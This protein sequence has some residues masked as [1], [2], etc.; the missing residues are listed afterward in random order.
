M[1]YL[2]NHKEEQLW[3]L[4][5]LRLTILL[6][7]AYVIFKIFQI[8]LPIDKKVKWTDGIINPNYMK[9]WDLHN[10]WSINH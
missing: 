3:T 2:L 5:N 7:I 9:A 8:L 1:I 6:S 4:G 10:F